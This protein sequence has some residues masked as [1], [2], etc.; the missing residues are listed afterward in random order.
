MG[1][2]MRR[3]LASR[4]EY[5]LKF[6]GRLGWWAVIG[7][8]KL[9]KLWPPGWRHRPMHAMRWAGHLDEPI[10][11][12]L[13]RK[14]RYVIELAMMPNWLLAVG[15]FG[16]GDRW[17]CPARAWAWFFPAE[18]YIRGIDLDTGELLGAWSFRKTSAGR[19]DPLGDDDL[20]HIAAR[21]A[22]TEEAV[23]P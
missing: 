11:I 23:A 16:E 7:V 5:F 18:Y 22:E 17:V 2:P 12:E 1:E 6:Y 19:V 13:P 20:A 3:M 21:A 15:I 9:L 4:K 14:C 8:E 10:E